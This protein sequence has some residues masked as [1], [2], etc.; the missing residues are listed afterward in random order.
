MSVLG[1][2]RELEKIKMIKE[3]GGAYRLDHAVSAT[4]KKKTK[5]F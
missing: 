1:A 3:I 2:I 4:Q 5:S